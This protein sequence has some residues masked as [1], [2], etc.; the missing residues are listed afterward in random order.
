MTPVFIQAGYAWRSG[1][2]HIGSLDANAVGNE[3]AALT[4]QSFKAIVTRAQAEDSAMHTYFEWDDAAASELW[5]VDQARELT[6][7]IV[8]VVADV[9]T[10]EE[11]Q[12][13]QR[14]FLSLYESNATQAGR[15]ATN[16]TTAI[17][18]RLGAPI[19]HKAKHADDSANELW[20]AEPTKEVFA[21]L[22][23][24][25]ALAPR[26]DQ[27]QATLDKLRRWADA[28]RGNPLFAGVIA[29]INAIG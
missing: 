15:F 3:I 22:I 11:V 2:R 10:E 19:E 14:A 5:R 20:D 18:V 24:P 4:D 25:V 13:D 1:T 17:P 6:R 26:S 7:A 23:R 27:D 29:A 9:T 8:L 28:F 21:P 16:E 12:T